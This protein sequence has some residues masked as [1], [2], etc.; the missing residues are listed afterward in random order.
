MRDTCATRARERAARL[1]QSDDD[2]EQGVGDRFAVEE[3]RDEV[4]APS[5]GGQPGGDQPR[6]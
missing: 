2:R 5:A 6:R 1:D 3:R 4:A